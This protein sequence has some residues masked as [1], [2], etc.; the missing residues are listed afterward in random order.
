MSAPQ[1]KGTYP[2]EYAADLHKLDCLEAARRLRVAAN[3]D[4]LNDPEF[5]ELYTAVTEH[6]WE[7]RAHLPDGKDPDDL[8]AMRDDEDARADYISEEVKALRGE[9]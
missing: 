9:K 7:R 8:L 4:E 6:R 3:L 1:D 5:W 2:P